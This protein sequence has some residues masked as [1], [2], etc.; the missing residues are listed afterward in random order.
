MRLQILSLLCSLFVFV[1]ATG[2]LEDKYKIE[3]LTAAFNLIFDRKDFDQLGTVFTPDVT[4]NPGAEDIQ[5]LPNVISAISTF[6]NKTTTYTTLGTQLIKFRPPFDKEGRSKLAE[7]VS[8]STIVNFGAGNL[9]G[10]SFLVFA[11]YV[12]KEIVKTNEPGFGGWR[13]KNR[14]FESIVSFYLCRVASTPPCCSKDFCLYNTLILVISR[15]NLSEIP[16][17]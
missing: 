1:L 14:K 7:S 4:Y 6:P 10:Q 13:F 8:Y 11:R 9:T 16:T 17:L 3:D 2:K 12:D 15:E 5:G